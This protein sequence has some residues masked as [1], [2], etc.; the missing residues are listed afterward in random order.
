MERDDVLPDVG[1]SRVIGFLEVLDDHKGVADTVRLVNELD[2][3]LDALLP[4]LDAAEMLG[5]IRIKSG[6]LKLTS[7]GK[8]LVES[9]LIARR[10]I[11]KERMLSLDVFKKVIAIIEARKNKRIHKKSVLR[12]LKE[13]LPQRE[14]EIQLQRVI[15]WGRH[16]EIIGYESNSEELYLIH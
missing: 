13:R 2:L 15:D 16:T 7:L 1:I 11:F 5:L 10:Q 3:E 6:K 9:N 14:A 4:V 8:K 12:Y